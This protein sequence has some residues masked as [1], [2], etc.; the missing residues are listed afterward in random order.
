MISPQWYEICK[1]TKV[2]TVSQLIA[3]GVEFGQKLHHMTL[4]S[5][6]YKAI[7]EG[8]KSLTSQFKAIVGDDCFSLQSKGWTEAL[9][10]SGKT[11]KEFKKD[12]LLKFHPDKHSG[13]DE[14]SKLRLK[15][16]ATTITQTINSWEEP[17]VEEGLVTTVEGVVFDWASIFANFRGISTDADEPLFDF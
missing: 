5:K 8:V 11:F 3:R 15:E 2:E 13:S 7:K 9:E 6:L 1:L 4:K 16:E 17:I 10:N 12:L 14:A